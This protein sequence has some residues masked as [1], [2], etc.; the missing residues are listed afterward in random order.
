MSINTLSEIKKIIDV[1]ISGLQTFKE[2]LN[3]ECECAINEIF[4]CK[5]KVVLTGMGKSGLIAKKIASTMASTGTLAMYMHPGE[6]MHGD[7]GMV[8]KEDIIMALSNSGESYEL[9]VVLSIVKRI[10]AKII[11][12]TGK[13]NSTL[14]K[15]ADIVL[16]YGEVKEACP[17]NVAPTTST[18][19]SL[20]LGDAIALT[21]MKMKDFKID[22]FALYHPGGRLGKQLIMKVS[23]IMLSDENNPAIEETSSIKDMLLKITEKQSGAISITDKDGKLAGIITDYN[24]R[25]VLQREK[26]IFSMQI[27]QIMTKSPV[28]VYDDEKAIKALEMMKDR[29]KPITVLP[30]VNRESVVVGMLRMHDIIRAGL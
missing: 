15:F 8:R 16:C 27:S 23:D 6:G 10:G 25:N 20:V 9:N 21:L 7:L 26:D 3:K 4:N 5:G 29:G 17:L 2:L 19:I 11:A 13:E 22:D 1:E 30:V 24:I 18:T 28:Y 14:A 12:I